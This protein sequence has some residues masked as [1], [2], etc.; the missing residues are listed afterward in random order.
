MKQIVS[1]FAVLLV[2]GIVGT[3]AG[4]NLVVNPN[5]DSDVAGWEVL[6]SS[7]YDVTWTGAMGANAPGAAQLDVHAEA[8]QNK[9]I[10]RQCVPVAPSTAYNVSAQIRFPSGVAQV[11]TGVIQVHWFLDGACI[12]SDAVIQTNRTVNSPDI[13][14]KVTTSRTSPAGAWSASVST[15]LIMSAGGTSQLWF[16]DIYFGPAEPSTRIQTWVPVASH[17]PGRNNS[18]WRSDL[19][20]LNIGAATANLQVRFHGTDGDASESGYLT[21]MV[22][23]IITDV[24]GQLGGSGSGALEILSDQP[25]VVTAR[26]YNL[27]ASDRDCYPNG[28]QGQDYPAVLSSGGLV[29]GQSAFLGGLT[30]NAASYRCNIGLVNTGTASATVVVEL[31]DGTGT[32]LTDYTM[33]L[34]PAEWKQETQPFLSKAGQTAMDRGF[35][36]VTVQ[37]GWGVFAFASVVDAITN[38]PTTVTMQR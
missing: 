29:A 9:L 26:T 25:L 2:L 8:A 24:V 19:G 1:S 35:A 34:A 13:W 6:L 10:F 18:Q 28:T 16:D 17:N 7:D 22:P 15:G 36:K 4:Q 5:F 12:V 32:K 23:A 14:Q 31:F 38:D 30:E 27:V 20:L 33:S 21:A 37:S 3:A 11:P